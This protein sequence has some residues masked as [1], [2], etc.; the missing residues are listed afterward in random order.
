MVPQVGLIIPLYVVLARYPQVNAL[1]GLVITYMTF[2]LPFC[3]WTLRGF[4]IGSRRNSRR[5]ALV[6][7][8]TRP[9]VFMKIL[10]PLMAPG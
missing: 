3:V 7:G 5:R 6:D 4:L 1:S 10:L 8:L 9:A 2:V